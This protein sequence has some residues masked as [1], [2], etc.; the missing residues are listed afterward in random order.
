MILRIIYTDAI[1]LVYVYEVNMNFHHSICAIIMAAGIGFAAEPSD[2]V[3]L[4]VPEGSEK[5]ENSKI[6]IP[7]AHKA[8]LGLLL[9][10]KLA[11]GKSFCVL[12]PD[13]A[14]EL[15]GDGYKAVKELKP[16]LVKWSF[17]E[18]VDQNGIGNVTA[19]EPTIH[20]KAGVLFVSST[21]IDIGEVARMVEGVIIVQVEKEPESV[22]VKAS[23]TGW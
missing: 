9:Y 8:K 12:T 10:D 3:P 22:V 11:K 21:G 7:L 4:A 14:K 17:L 15:A 20:S 16:I 23:K 2:Y 19:H 13:Q 1:V 6:S 5:V 18:P